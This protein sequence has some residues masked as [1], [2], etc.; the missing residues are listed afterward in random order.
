M[1]IVLVFMK[2]VLVTVL[3]VFCAALA[4]ATQPVVAIH[5]SELTRA[6]ETMPA[7]GATPTGPGTTSNQW[8]TTQWH[9]FVMPESVKEALRSDGTAFTVVGYSNN[10][11]G[12]LINADGSPKYPIVISLASEAIRNDEIAQLTN[13]VAA[14]GFLFVGSSAFTRNT[15]GTTRDDFAFANELGVHMVN[16]GLTNWGDNSTFSKLNNHR[17]V[18]HIPDG[19]IEWDMPYSAEDIPYGVAPDNAF[20]TVHLAWQVQAGDAS[21]IADG[22]TY[23]YLL[24]K[25]FGR[26]YFIYSAAMQP[27]IGHGGND[28]GMYAYG[29]FRNAIEW[30]FE[31]AKLPIPKLSPWPYPYDA[32]LEIRHD[33]EAI[34]GLI[35]QCEASAR[36]E[37]TN[38]AAGDYYFCTGELRVN[39]GLTD[40][41]NEIASLRRAASLYGATISSHNGGLT[42]PYT[43]SVPTDYW[44][45]HWGPDEV[46]DV[47]VTSLGYTTGKAYASTSI[48]NSFLNI[49][50]WL[51][52]LTNGDGR[53]H[54]VSPAFNSTRED[55][56]DIL[57]RLGVVTAG[58]E[59]LT[60]FPHWTLST[61]TSGKRYSFL[62]LP[63]SDWYVG[64]TVAQ[65]LENHTT[66][67][68]VDALVDFYYS[69][70][71]LINLY[72][73]SSSA[74]GASPPDATWANNDLEKEY[75]TYSM[76]T[77]LHPRLWPAN[78]GIIYN[79]WLRRGTAVIVP[80]F[81]KS[82]MQSVATFSITGAS[83]PQTAVEAVIPSPSFSSLQVFTN[84]IAA[85]P[86]SYRTNGQVIKI[87]VGTSVT[88]AEVHYILSP[89]AQ[90]DFYSVAVGT[91]LT[92]D[93]PGVL[94][95]D[96]VSGGGNLTAVLVGGPAHGALDLSAD[97]SFT[98]TP[99]PDYSGLD[100]F[101][102]VANDGTVDS[103]VA[104]V[105]ISVIS[106]SG[107][108]F[109]DDFTRTNDPGT[110]SPWILHDGAWLITGGVLQSASGPPSYAHVYIDS[111]WTNYSVEGQVAF[112]A[113]ATVGGGGL[114]GC[115]DPTTGA[116][117]AAWIYPDGSP[118]GSPDTLQLIKF[119][120]WT[121]WSGTAMGTVSLPSV[122]TNWHTL[123]L[124]FQ[125]NEIQVYYDGGLK[126]DV[127]DNGFDGRSAYMS[128]GIC[129][130]TYEDASRYAML[131]DNVVVTAIA[132]APLAVND[133]YSVNE[134]TTLNV[135][136]PGVLANDTPGGGSGSLSAVLVTNVTQGTLTLSADGSFSYTPGTNFF[137]TDS[138]AYQASDGQMN[139]AIATVTITVIPSSEVLFSDDFTRTNYP[140]SLLP[141]WLEYNG[142]TW[143]IVGG[144]LQ[145]TSGPPEDY[146]YAYIAT[147]WTDYSVGGRIRFPSALSGGGG[148]GGRFDSAT[149]AHYGVWIFPDN[150]PYGV[151]NVL[152]L[153]K[154][155]DWTTWS[156]T[157]MAEVNLASVGT[158]W[159]SLKLAFKGDQI[160][161]YYDG[162]LVLSANDAVS[163]YVS[164]GISVETFE[165]LANYPMSADDI[166]VSPLATDDSYSL[167]ENTSL[168]V[169]APGVLNND[170][171]VYG[172][173]L[174]AVL[175]TDP[176]H[177]TLNLTN[178]GG[179]IYIPATNYNGS[180]S[181]VYQ[182]N[183][184]QTNLGTAT[185]TIAVIP[186][187]ALTVTASNETRAYGTTNP[188]LRVSYS[189]FVNGDDTNVLTGAPV[190]STIATTNSPVGSY[191]ITVSQGTLSAT[192][193]NF[194]FVNGTLTVTQAV[195]TITSGIAANNKTYDG[196]TV[197]TISSN[198][199]VLNGVV[200]G[201]AANVK[202][203]TNGYTAS[204]ASA[205]V[206]N[207]IGVTVCGLTLTGAGATNYT[208]TQ[209][210]GLTA[211]I[212]SKGV[213]ITSGITANNKT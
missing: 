128:G 151:T 114:G 155:T 53:R 165:N 81:T 49:E 182:A 201:D 99:V 88:N 40:R 193:Y 122:G 119:R 172:T 61:E 106:A 17:L 175:V 184:D 139:S 62:S 104:T 152:R 33:L 197:A 71:A 181:F 54:W 109:F 162:V 30:A 187:F 76:N 14:G 145:S 63:V 51:S 1:K 24:V 70:G 209:P 5:D 16:P 141:P 6:L 20:N 189:G 58:E 170:T 148:L 44:Y 192:N 211:N 208:L 98:Y 156:G 15:N 64:S 168:S 96:F 102:Y 91:T 154:F 120:D 28:S 4:Q 29:I 169:P 206:A 72:S 127:T 135:A 93:A 2:T 183:D 118:W 39:Y 9:Y 82:G 166:V 25:Q 57:D 133:S 77:S 34:P 196:T 23:P 108:L 149:G 47:N 202:L 142:N 65:S 123:K 45:W 159:H 103:S 42:N 161:V 27:L 59:K 26:G 32:A 158:N 188:V 210:A 113:V 80:G 86:S 84:G 68:T 41:T 121:S 179:F 78:A 125:G 21:V 60:P 66:A 138:F 185:V 107:A 75:V 79:W 13:Y 143:T 167:A 173:N 144:E 178:N 195:L 94:G 186:A 89:E 200:A 131:V 194:V 164:G 19:V 69:W 73:H 56:K 153:L 8:W 115:L 180:D 67:E 150:S 43:P 140:A 12:V 48:S 205:G 18:S 90:D 176:A 36:F 198:N 212:T 31:S 95:N 97:G 171:G 85:G 129:V 105:T 22:D 110:L 74:G 132:T 11:A 52:G 37:H 117:Y 213:T 130:D 190:I 204:F 10:L 116:H 92:V 136:A 35:N 46:L 160:G 174:T 191:T 124:T 203:S 134:N 207:G 146:A 111:N 3:C 177:G 199:V 55:S 7:S 112:P 147:N 50:G 137:G 101:S 100:S 87:L 83:D 163:T 38:G 126:I 157:P